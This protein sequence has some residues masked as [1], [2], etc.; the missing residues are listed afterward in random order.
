MHKEELI[1]KI[2][3]KNPQLETRC[4]RA[5]GLYIKAI[6]QNHALVRSQNSE[7]Y[8]KVQLPSYKCN[9]TDYRAGGAPIA[10]NGI[11]YC[12]HGLAVYIEIKCYYEQEE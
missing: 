1:T 3:A 8:Y 2:I 10:S 12:K 6:Y 9:C 11:R 4:E 5:S 7:E